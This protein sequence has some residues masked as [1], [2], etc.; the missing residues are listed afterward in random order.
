MDAVIVDVVGGVM[1]RIITVVVVRVVGVIVVR[2]GVIVVGIIVVSVRA[3][4][5]MV[6][7]VFMRI[8][9]RIKIGEDG[10]VQLRAAAMVHGE[11]RRRSDSRIVQ[12]AGG[13]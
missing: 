11:R 9:T 8:S 2:V 6:M 4:V 7:P 12:T 10:E 5:I 13:R 1:R 3:Q